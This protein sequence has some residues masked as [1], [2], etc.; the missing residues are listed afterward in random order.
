MSM[1][2]NTTFSV[3]VALLA[4]GVDRNCCMMMPRNSS[5]VALLA[6]GVDRNCRRFVHNAA[7]SVVALLAEG[8]D[9]NRKYKQTVNG[10]T[11]RPPRGGRG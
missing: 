2:L 10:K 4:E 3:A 7:K 1:A 6:E 5:A 9:R 11:G 8:V